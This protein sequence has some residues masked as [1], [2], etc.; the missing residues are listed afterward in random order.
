MKLWKSL[1]K[2]KKK[3]KKPLQLALKFFCYRDTVVY[4]KAI[5][6]LKLRK[7]FHYL[8]LADNAG[9]SSNAVNISNQLKDGIFKNSNVTTAKDVKNEISYENRPTHNTYN[10]HNHSALPASKI[11]SKPAP[12][13]DL[14]RSRSSPTK[15]RKQ[16]AA[17]NMPTRTK[18]SKTTALSK[19]KK[20]NSKAQKK[21][22]KEISPKAKKPQPARKSG[23]TTVGTFKYQEEK[24]LRQLPSGQGALEHLR[25]TFEMTVPV[26]K[27]KD[28]GKQKK[29]SRSNQASGNIRK[30]SAGGRGVRNGEH[31]GNKNSTRGRGKKCL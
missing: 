18:A 27:T 23:N 20:T 14:R 16:T 4:W 1:K 31:Q 30:K 6:R 22:T 21:I 26:A 7:Q 19:S 2:T 5:F 11:L 3:H 17:S 28:Q 24:V 13:Q 10:I 12:K 25:K 8:Y 15:Q 29:Q 9:S